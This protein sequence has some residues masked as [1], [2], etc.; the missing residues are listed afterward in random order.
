VFRST[1]L[2]SLAFALCSA[3][4]AGSLVACRQEPPNVT[5]H[6]TDKDVVDKG[7]MVVTGTATMQVSPDLAD[8]VM[9]LEGKSMRPG[10][11]ASI[12]RKKQDQLVLALRALG[13]E[14]ADLK[15]STLS[16]E[17][18]YEWIEN[19]Q[20]F[21]GY[22]S[23]IVITATTRKFDLLGAMMEAGGQAGAVQMS[24]MF[25]RSDLDDLKKK[26]RELALLA[27]RDKAQQSAKVLGFEL[28]R[29]S[30]IV[31]DGHSYMFNNYY[32]PAVANVMESDGKVVANI[33]AELQPLTLNVTLT[34]DLPDEA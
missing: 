9:T 3:G 26:V 34:Y 29:I 21:K 5:I 15:L 12:V 31:E 25:R 2:R 28:G 7:R 8:L 22:T 10:D 19:R 17:P 11:A 23:R 20:V 30:A 27:A 33:G 1:S 24:S 14:D 4:A 16:I 6:T 32:F 18:V 13:I